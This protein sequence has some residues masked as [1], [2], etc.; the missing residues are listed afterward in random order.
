MVEEESD[1]QISS[2]EDEESEEDE[3]AEWYYRVCEAADAVTT[4]RSPSPELTQDRPAARTQTSTSTYRN[5]TIIDESSRLINDTTRMMLDDLAACAADDNFPSASEEQPHSVTVTLPS[6]A[7]RGAP[8]SAN[9]RPRSPSVEI[10]ATS[11]ERHAPR[12]HVAER[13]RRERQR[14]YIQQELEDEGL[15]CTGFRIP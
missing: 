15:V 4:T 11:L 8:Q 10:I 1:R 5:G 6:G 3:E 9:Q 2:D 13:T 14:E 12:R 7:S